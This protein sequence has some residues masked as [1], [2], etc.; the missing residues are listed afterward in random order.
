MFD[1]FKLET[2]LLS[3]SFRCLRVVYRSNSPDGKAVLVLLGSFTSHGHRD[4]YGNKCLHFVMFFFYP[5]DM[6]LFQINQIKSNGFKMSNLY[7]FVPNHTLSAK[8]PHMLLSRHAILM[9]IDRV[10]TRTAVIQVTHY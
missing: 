3:K 4:H 10:I 6:S 8:C 1:L 9:E 7:A 2:S 5:L